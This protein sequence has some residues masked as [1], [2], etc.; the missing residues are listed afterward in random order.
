M[1][2]KGHRP[3]KKIAYP[4]ICGRRAVHATVTTE[5]GAMAFKNEHSFYRAVLAGKEAVLDKKYE[6]AL[7][8]LEKKAGRRY[9]MVINGREEFSSEGEFDSTSPAATDIVL[10]RFQKGTPENV[11]AAVAAAKAAYPH[12]ESA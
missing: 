10:G 12:S 4:E 5:G 8:R 11:N 3:D 1:D 9:P 7:A 2:R 6:K